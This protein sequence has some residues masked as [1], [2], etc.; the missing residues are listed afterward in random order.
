MHIFA[1]EKPVD[2][3]NI[4]SQRFVECYLELSKVGK[5]K[6]ARHFA[7]SL[8][9]LPQSLH[10]I[11]KGTRD[12]SLELI[13]KS[14]EV[15]QINSDYLFTG[16]GAKF[17]SSVCMDDLKVITIQTD[18]F[19]NEKII[20]IPEK[21]HAGYVENFGQA[22]YVEKLETYSIPLHNFSSQNTMR[23]FEV[24]GDSMQPCFMAGDIVV[25]TYVH[26]YF[27]ETKLNSS[28]SFVFVTKNGIVLKNPIAYSKKENQVILTSENEEYS[29]YAV[30]VTDIIEVWE[31]EFKI[32]KHF[33]SPIYKEE[34]SLEELK[35]LLLQQA[36]M[37][38]KISE[39]QFHGSY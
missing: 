12:I 16:K 9:C 8:Q 18:H 27:W 28:K 30:A 22:H 34:T 36:E 2:V 25:C 32:T 15:F 24:A 1:L 7:Q 3:H 4:V 21:A 33:D 20:H 11:L 31:V 26:S 37:I 38:K 23:S 10:P 14:V 29:P 6:S 39:A 17:S 13:S 35:D 5:V 19:G